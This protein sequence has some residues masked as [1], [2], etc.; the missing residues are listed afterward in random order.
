[1]LSFKKVE[2]LQ[3]FYRAHIGVTL[4]TKFVLESKVKNNVFAKFIVSLSAHLLWILIE[5]LEEVIPILKA[6]EN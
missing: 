5:I 6:T 3:K 1:M 2:S 4:V